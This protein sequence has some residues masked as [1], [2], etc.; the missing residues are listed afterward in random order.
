MAGPQRWQVDDWRGPQGARPVKAF[1]D[2]LSEAA[3]DRIA[4]HLEMLAREGNA[5]RFPRSR[6][7][8]GGIFE[9][10]IAVPDGAIRFLYCFLRGDRVIVLHGFA[11]K[12]QKTPPDDLALA[13]TRKAALT[14]EG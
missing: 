9:L 2:G 10:R 8:G 1:L 3:R 12:T 4:A 14:K 13:R 5:L 11:K 6:P 7:L